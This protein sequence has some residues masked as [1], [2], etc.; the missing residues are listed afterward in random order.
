MLH[1]MEPTSLHAVTEKTTYHLRGAAYIRM[2]FVFNAMINI[3]AVTF[4]L[5]NWGMTGQYDFFANAFSWLWG[6]ILSPALAGEQAYLLE[7][8][9]EAFV[10]CKY[11]GGRLAL[12]LAEIERVEVTENKPIFGGKVVAGQCLVTFVSKK[13]FGCFDAKK[14][15]CNIEE[16]STFL[17]D[18]GLRAPEASRIVEI[19][20]LSN[21]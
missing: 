3:V 11:N 15:R 14:F 8:N 19:T 2:F 9:R 12:P 16:I 6:F 20:P 13:G 17:S 5:V 7:R 4:S 18:T 10:L 21:V 1:S